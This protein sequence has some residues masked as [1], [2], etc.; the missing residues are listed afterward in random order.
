MV[1]D[2][3]GKRPRVPC[4]NEMS[5]ADLPRPRH[6]NPCRHIRRTGQRYSRNWINP[7]NL[8]NDDGLRFMVNGTGA[9]Y[10]WPVGI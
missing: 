6:P 7:R 1:D 3:F 2:G 8:I 5:S 10:Q 9:T 4:P